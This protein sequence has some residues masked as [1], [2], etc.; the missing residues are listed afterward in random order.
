M[1]AQGAEDSA[2]PW[3]AALL[4][5]GFGLTP[6]VSIFAPKALALVAG[7][8][9]LAVLAETAFKRRLGSGR[10]WPRPPISTAIAV[11]LFLIWAMIST[12]WAPLPDALWE[13]WPKIAA[14]GV[15]GLWFLSWSHC[16]DAVLCRRIGLALSV[17]VL[18]GI[19]LLAVDSLTL[20]APRRALI[21]EPGYYGLASLNRAGAVAAILVWPAAL[22]LHKLT[23]APYRRLLSGLP[24]VGLALVLLT[25]ESDSARAAFLAALA[26]VLLVVLAGRTGCRVLGGVL[27]GLTMLAPVLP[28]TLLAPERILN[29]IAGLPSTMVH[30]LYIWQ[31]AAERIAEKPLHGWGYA[32]SRVLPGG[33]AMVTDIAPDLPADVYGAMER[34][35]LHPHN[36]PLQVWLELG[37]PGA[38]AAGLLIWSLFAGAARLADPW[39]RSCTVAAIV[40][41]LAPISFSYGLWQGWWL[42]FLCL[43]AVA[44]VVA[45]RMAAAR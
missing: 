17:G 13:R 26:S 24:I 1:T 40:A 6:A 4:M 44:T 38:L 30:R 20:G 7:L 15:L 42:S 29:L 2:A 22:A 11:A 14:V 31:F 27:A 19:G 41:A 18:V 23:A 8:L 32:A 12:H 45:V 5:V 28:L 9:S 36:G 10:P 33:K 16:A 35:P 25:L 3:L 34:L 39:S 43:A 37:L 21:D